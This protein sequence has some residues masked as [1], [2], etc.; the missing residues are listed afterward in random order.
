[1]KVISTNIGN[2]KEIIWQGEKVFT[3]IYKYPVNEAIKLDFH[4]VDKDNVIDRRYHGG[5]DKACYLYSAD[6]Y[7]FWQNKYP[8]IEWQWGMFGENI[9]MEGLN[10]NNV[11]IG[12][13]FRL[14]TA[15]VQITQPR[16]PCF[17]LGIRLENNLAVKEFVKAEL[18]GAYLKVLEKGIVKTGD[19]MKV[20]ESK[21]N[22]FS[23]V[24]VFHLIYNAKS[25]II[26]VKQ[27]IKMPELAESC[28]NDLIKY[29]GL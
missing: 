1:M 12:D 6:H 23:L 21:P 9:T 22:N 19:E 8:D 29:A 25:N 26:K 27:A 5:I 13:I 4:D 20:L 28:R 3:G 7:G 10:E 24:E 17:K 2:K 16:Q 18:P 14:G 11:K 15:L